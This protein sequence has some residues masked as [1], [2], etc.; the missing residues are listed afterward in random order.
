M[1]KQTLRKFA[2]KIIYMC[3]P[4]DTYIAPSISFSRTIGGLH[5]GYYI[6]Y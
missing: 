6:Q 4:L 3:T 2:L 5:A 1:N